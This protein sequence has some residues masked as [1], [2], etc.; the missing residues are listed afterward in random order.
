ME[1]INRWRPRNLLLLLGCLSSGAL[2]MAVAACGGISTDYIDG[3]ET[4]SWYPLPTD[5][6]EL[7]AMDHGLIFE[8]EVLGSEAPRR[9]TARA[10][11]VAVQYAYTPVAVEVVG[12]PAPERAP[13]LQVGKQLYL[14]VL[15]GSADGKSGEPVEGGLPA[16]VFQ[17]GL[18]VLVMAQPLVDVGDGLL[19][20][21]PN[22][23]L[24]IE[25]G[26]A[27]N[28]VG[29]AEVV[30]LQVLRDLVA[31]APVSQPLGV[32]GPTTTSTTVRG[33]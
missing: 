2:L 31:E 4:W 23:V 13:G 10:A 27:R 8:A 1:I 20:A 25:E 30:D 11:G 17:P 14:R 24:I 6:G 9:V 28:A 22:A 3:R 33:G 16:S 15:G 7:A 21:T 26:R 32:P 12:L 29:G 18:Q 19:A 5:V